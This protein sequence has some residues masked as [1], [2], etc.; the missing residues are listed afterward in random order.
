[1]VC[2][3][4][5]DPVFSSNGHLYFYD[6]IVTY[7]NLQVDY[8]IAY[9]RSII[10]FQIVQ[11]C[12]F[13][14]TFCIYTIQ[15]FRYWL[16]FEAKIASYV[17]LFAKWNWQKKNNRSERVTKVTI[18]CSYCYGYFLSPTGDVA[19]FYGGIIVAVAWHSRRFSSQFASLVYLLKN[20]SLTFVHTRYKFFPITTR[21]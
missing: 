20:C 3:P 21:E 5:I 17:T 19:H 16:V 4:I 1:M 9:Q 6:S 15:Q 8:I 7:M 12:D 18:Y 10:Y 13:L 11:Y 14:T 2:R